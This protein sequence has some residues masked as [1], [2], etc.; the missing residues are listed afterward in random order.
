V[1]QLIQRGVLQ[2]GSVVRVVHRDQTAEGTLNA[3]G[4]ITAGEETF[5][6]C[7]DFATAVKRR[8]Q[9]NARADDGWR[10]CTVNNRSLHDYRTEVAET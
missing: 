6:N 4:T 10:S 7:G 2:A 8:A 9:S 3:D 5:K 1:E